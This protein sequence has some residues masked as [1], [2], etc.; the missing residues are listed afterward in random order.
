MLLS[1]IKWTLFAAVV[2]LLGQIHVGQETIAGAFQA[3]LLK[4]CRLGGEQVRQSRLFA[5]LP[6]S[7]VIAGL[8]PAEPAR[9]QAR[10]GNHPRTARA[11]IETPPNDSSEDISET[12][13]DTLIRMLP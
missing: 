2:L 10:L 9:P 1:L 12:D 11:A 6:G 7:G 3:R 4:G 8:L 5:T 13:R